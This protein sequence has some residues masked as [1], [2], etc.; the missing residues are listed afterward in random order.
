MT[1]RLMPADLLWM[2]LVDML[3]LLKYMV[4]LSTWSIMTVGIVPKTCSAKF[5]DLTTS[6]VDT[7]ESTTRLKRSVF[8]T[9]TALALPL[10]MTVELEHLLMRTECEIDASISIGCC[11]FS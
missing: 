5:W 6:T 10:I 9:V 1:L 11:S 4:A 8:S 3:S 2:I 7:S